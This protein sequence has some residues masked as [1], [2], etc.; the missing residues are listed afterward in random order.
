MIIKHER[1]VA[2]IADGPVTARGDRQMAGLNGLP[3]D[4]H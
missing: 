2:P 1:K 3:Q 4:P